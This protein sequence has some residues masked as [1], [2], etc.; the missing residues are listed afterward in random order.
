MVG[1]VGHSIPRASFVEEIIRGNEQM[2]DKK[3]LGQAESRENPE[4][5]ELWDSTSREK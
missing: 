2:A 5:P 1:A 3:Q 4:G